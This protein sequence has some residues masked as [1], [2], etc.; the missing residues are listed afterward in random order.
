M[1]TDHKLSIPEERERAIAAG[2]IVELISAQDPSM[3]W[4]VRA[5]GHSTRLRMSRSLGDFYLKTCEERERE[6]QIVTADPE[7]RIYQR[8]EK[9]VFILLACDGVFDVMSNQEA[10]DNIARSLGYYEE[11]ERERE[12]GWRE[13]VTERELA[14]ACDTLLTECL[15]LGSTD[16]MTVMIILLSSFSL[17]LSSSS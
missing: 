9:E 10:V 12:T 13:R 2:G 1:T 7:I 11:R 16:N 5:N 15:R 6:K 17:S 8:T 14:A 4:E 3:G